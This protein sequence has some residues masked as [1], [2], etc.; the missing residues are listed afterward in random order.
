MA[1]DLIRFKGAGDVLVEVGRVDPARPVSGA[2]AT[3]VAATFASAIKAVEPMLLPIKE[4]IE[5]ALDGKSL[6]KAEVTMGLGL[7][8]DGNV[9]L[10][11]AK[12]EANFEVKLT[13]ERA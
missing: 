9:F 13:F 4:L 1:D 3:P 11:K 12:G 7:S 6:K 2:S 8:V 10:V 5:K